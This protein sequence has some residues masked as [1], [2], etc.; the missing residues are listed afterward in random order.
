MLLVDIPKVTS[1][2]TRIWQKN[3]WSLVTFVLI[4]SGVISC[5]L[6]SQAQIWWNKYPERY[7]EFPKIANII[8]Q[9]NKPLLISDTDNL[10]PPVQILGHL[11]DPKVRFQIVEK[12]QLPEITNGFTDIFLLLYEPSDFLKAG[13]EKVYNSKLQQINHFFWK[14]T[15]PT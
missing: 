15:K 12:N 7:Q 5:T 10:L 1:I 6:N 4:I 11:V 3:L 2:H 8:S 9:G 13:V 14:V